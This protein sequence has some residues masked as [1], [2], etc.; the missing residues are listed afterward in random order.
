[1]LFLTPAC[2]GLDNVHTRTTG[3][4]SQASSTDFRVFHLPLS[5]NHACMQ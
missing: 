3:A 2:P 1:M 4:C 5:R